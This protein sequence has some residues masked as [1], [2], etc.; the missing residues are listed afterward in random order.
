MRTFV[1]KVTENRSGHQNGEIDLADGSFCLDRR[2]IPYRE[3]E[4]VSCHVLVMFGRDFHN[5]A[6]LPAEKIWCVSRKV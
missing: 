5:V 6:H 3:Q 1:N 4:R 2:R